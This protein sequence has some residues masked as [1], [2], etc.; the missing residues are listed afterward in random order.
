LP[1]GKSD[2]FSARSYFRQGKYDVLLLADLGRS[3][4]IATF[5]KKIHELSR[6]TRL[7]PDP[8]ISIAI[9]LALRRM[10]TYLSASGHRS[11]IVDAPPPKKSGDSRCQLLTTLQKR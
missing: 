7:G 1:T 3:P 11:N 8:D 5:W 6:H 9:T 4:S 2:V 10:A